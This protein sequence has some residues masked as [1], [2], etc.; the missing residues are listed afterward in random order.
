[1]GKKMSFYESGYLQ[2]TNKKSQKSRNYGTLS[3]HGRTFHFD[4][5]GGRTVDF[6]VDDIIDIKQKG[7]RVV[8]YLENNKLWSF[9]IMRFQRN[10]KL[11]EVFELKRKAESMIGLIKYLKE[12]EKSN[13]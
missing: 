5:R 13:E 6:N 4:G 9:A 8:M 10:P 11:M 2:D 7:V 1:M 12:S 3:L